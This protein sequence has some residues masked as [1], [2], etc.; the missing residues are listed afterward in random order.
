MLPQ[1]V[2]TSKMSI[3]SFKSSH[4]KTLKLTF[5]DPEELPELAKPVLA[6]LFTLKKLTS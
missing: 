5:I 6:L 3:S 2:L 1:E 4:Q